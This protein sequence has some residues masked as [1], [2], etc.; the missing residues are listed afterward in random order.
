MSFRGHYKIDPRRD[1]S[2]G[3][4]A[5]TGR[6]VERDCRAV[7]DLRGIARWRSSSEGGAGCV[8]RDPV[9][10][11]DGHWLERSP[12]RSLR[13]VLKDVHQTD[14]RL[15]GNRAVATDARVVP[16]EA[17]Q[18]RSARLVSGARRLQLG[19]SPAG[20]AKTGPNPTDRGR[21]GSKHCLLT[22]AT[23]VPLVIQLAPANQHDVKTLLPLVVEIPA[24]AGKPGRPKQKPES[25][26]ADKAFDCEALRQLLRWLGIEPHLPRR[27]DD[28]HGLGVLR[29]FV[30]RTISWLHQF[31][32]LRIRWDRR[33]DIHQSFLSLAAAVV[34]FRLWKSES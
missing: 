30:E 7:S 32:R 9:R 15:D 19:E 26:L 6:A 13:G 28:E 34:C 16:G 2:H 18:C 1:V 3:K 22:D 33:P 17:S 11:K 24:V 31:R 25:L 29:W 4:Q 8:D 21:S 14:C 27:G 20:R 12:D 10:I 5:A 23:G